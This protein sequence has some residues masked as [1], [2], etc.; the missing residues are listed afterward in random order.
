MYLIILVFL[1]KLVFWF[2]YLYCNFN[3]IQVFIKKF[4]YS[5]SSKSKYISEY[6]Y[7]Y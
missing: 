3:S 5:Y 6:I 2:V 4:Y 1:Y 7:D